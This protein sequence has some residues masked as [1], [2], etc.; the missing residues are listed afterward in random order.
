[1]ISLTTR[2]VGN[3]FGTVGRLRVG[4]RSVETDVLPYGFDGPAKEQ[5]YEA[6]IKAGL[7]REVGE[8]SGEYDRVAA[9]CRRA[10]AILLLDRYVVVA[11][12]DQ[13][14]DALICGDIERDL[15]AQ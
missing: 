10:G 3:H 13:R 2:T 1:M 5:A 8:A 4:T 11:A 12:T 7:L 14:S 9:A 6:A 15:E